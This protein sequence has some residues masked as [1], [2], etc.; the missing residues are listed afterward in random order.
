MTSPRQ[1]YLIGG[2]IGL[3]WVMTQLSAPRAGQAAFLPLSSPAYSALAEADAYTPPIP[4]TLPM[5]VYGT[6]TLNGSLAPDGTIVRAV[7]SS[8]QVATANVF[9]SG[10]QSGLYEMNVPADDPDT[11]E[12]DGGQPGQTVTFAVTGY[13]IAQTTTWNSGAVVNLNLTGDTPTNM[14]TSTQ[15]PTAT[16]T[17]THT[18]TVTGGPTSTPTR[19]PTGTLTATSTP[20]PTRTPT[21]TATPTG[22]LSPTPTSTSSPSGQRKLYLPLIRR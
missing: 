9:T 13:V 11:A 14:P 4:P 18:P 12:I 5:T 10:G 17:P 1:F 7:I 8:T 19:T 6:V 15:T 22:T 3:F 20:T 16:A 2:L 21:R